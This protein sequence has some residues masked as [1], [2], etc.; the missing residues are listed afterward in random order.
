MESSRTRISGTQDRYADVDV[1]QLLAEYVGVCNRALAENMDSFLFRQAKRLS[2]A[3][4]EDARFRTVVYDGDPDNV[5]E[6]AII[7]FDPH[8]RLLRLDNHGDGEITFTW[9][10]PLAYLQDVVRT[11]P[12]WYA[13]NPLMLDW[14]WF[15]G[16]VSDEWRHAKHDRKIIVGGAVL[17]L[18]GVMIGYGASRMLHDKGEAVDR[19]W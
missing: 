8:Q 10:V 5:L 16:R 2:R 4:W 17:L 12:D 18:A 9:K 7:R 13:D 15:T 11:R 14:K 6:E 19:D 3:M 1:R